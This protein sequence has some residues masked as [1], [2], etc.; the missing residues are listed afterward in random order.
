MPA[1]SNSS[2]SPSSNNL[3]DDSVVPEAERLFDQEGEFSTLETGFRQI[4]DDH[5]KDHADYHQV[6][7]GLRLRFISFAESSAAPP[8]ISQHVSPNPLRR[9]SR[10]ILRSLEESQLNI[11]LQ[12]WRGRLEQWTK[13]RTK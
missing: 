5:Y 8:V 1:S 12:L 10:A 7:P 13:V 11:L 2:G 9:T 3:D 4:A 6:K